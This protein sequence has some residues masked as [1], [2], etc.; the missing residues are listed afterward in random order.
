MKPNR[1]ERPYQCTASGPEP[2]RDRIDIGIGKPVESP[3][4]NAACPRSG[5]RWRGA[6]S[7]SASRRR[8]RSETGSP[9]Q[10]SD[11]LPGR[12]S[13]LRLAVRAAAG[14]SVSL[15][16]DRSSLE[17][18]KAERTRR[19]GPASCCTRWPS[20]PASPWSSCSSGSRPARSARSQR[21]QGLDRADR[22][23]RRHH[24]RSEHD[25]HLPDP[26]PDD[27]QTRCQCAAPTA[28]CWRRS[29]SGSVSRPAGRRA[30]GRFLPAILLLASQE[31]IGAATFLLFVYSMGLAIPFLLT[32]AAITQALALLNRIKR[33][34]RRDRDRRRS[35]PVAIGIVLVTDRSRA[36]QDS[37][38]S[39]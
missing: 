27:G 9:A 11:R 39:S 33:Y 29:W 34:L 38:I 7:F 10:C 17:E 14:P 19:S 20:S 23:H 13:L 8:G 30:S 12:A 28:R 22:R 21:L 31:Q 37:S 3:C 24:P 5:Y 1:Y 2:E 26:V 15:V 4:E 18:L 32:A 36:S 35:V 25:G 16:P 6:G